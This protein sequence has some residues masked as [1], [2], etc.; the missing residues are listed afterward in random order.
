MYLPSC[1]QFASITGRQVAGDGTAVSFAS[2]VVHPATLDIKQGG[3][4]EAGNDRSRLGAWPDK[5]D[6]GLIPTTTAVRHETR[7]RRRGMRDCPRDFTLGPPL[8]GGGRGG[9]PRSPVFRSG[10]PKGLPLAL[11]ERKKKESSV[12]YTRHC[13]GLGNRSPARTR[14]SSLTRSRNCVI[15]SEIGSP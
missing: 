11:A 12:S 14:R 1:H 6:R 7:H 15:I 2:D 13:D 4:G 8:E 5:H 10:I 9:F 3:Q